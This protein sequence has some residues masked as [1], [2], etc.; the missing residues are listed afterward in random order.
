MSWIGYIDFER[1]Y[2]FALESAFFVTRTKENVF[3]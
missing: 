3:R 2:R 1:L